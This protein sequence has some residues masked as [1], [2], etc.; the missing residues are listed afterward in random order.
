[1]GI[2][3]CFLQILNCFHPVAP[4]I[5]HILRRQFH[6]CAEKIKTGK[7]FDVYDSTL[8]LLSSEQ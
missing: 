2:A 1:M 3:F 5:T 4:V 6:K 8:S 7:R